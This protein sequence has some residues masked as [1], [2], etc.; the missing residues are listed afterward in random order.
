MIR[1]S[2]DIF[3]GL[4]ILHRLQVSVGYWLFEPNRLLS[5]GPLPTALDSLFWLLFQQLCFVAVT[6]F[7]SENGSFFNVLYIIM[8]FIVL[9]SD[10]IKT[11]VFSTKKCSVCLR[12]V[13]WCCLQHLKKN[14]VNSQYVGNNWVCFWSEGL[15]VIGDFFFSQKTRQ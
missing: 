11:W 7:C 4:W 5:H 14:A 9:S 15:L 13:H 10:L 2:C 12:H 8:F 1:I 3:Q 6:V